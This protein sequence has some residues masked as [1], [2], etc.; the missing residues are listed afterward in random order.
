VL[1]RLPIKDFAE[2]EAS[3]FLL[4][5]FF[6]FDRYGLLIIERHT[7]G[8]IRGLVEKQWADSQANLITLRQP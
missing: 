5:A 8:R 1:S 2:E 3:L 6:H 4:F 7:G